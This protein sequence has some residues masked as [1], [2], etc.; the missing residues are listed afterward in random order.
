MGTV[1]AGHQALLVDLYELTMAAGYFENEVNY[2]STF[3]L[4]VRELP[5][6]R[7]YLVAAG[8]EQVVDFLESVQFQSEEIEFLRSHPTFAHVRKEF[9]DYLKH[10]RFSG[11]LWAMP[12]GTLVFPGEPIL[13]VSAPLI[14]AQIMETYLLSMINCQTMIATKATRVVAAA[15]GR[16]VIEFG[17][18]RAHGPEAGVLAARAAY[19]GGC[20]GTSNVYAGF[21]MGIPIYGTAAHSW[22]MT[23]ED[24]EEAFEKYCRVFPDSALLLID[25]YNTVEGARKAARMGQKVKGVRI[26]SGDLLKTSQQVRTILDDAGLSGVQILASGDLNE[27]KVR[28]LVQHGAPIDVFGVGTELSTSHDAP[29]LGGVYKLV[30]QTVE[31][32]F[33]YRIKLSPQKATYPGKKQVFRFTNARDQFDHDVIARD[34]ES[35]QG[36]PLLERVMAEGHRLGP[37]PALHIARERAALNF[38][39]LQE[40]YAAFENPD[41]YPVINSQALEELFQKMKHLN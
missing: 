13:R 32:S 40:R 39:R 14:E 2:P 17:S 8:L 6:K 22:T 3:E 12:E 4:F 11:D 9:F 23:F 35:S 31:N 37:L 7:S 24:E 33:R 21:R 41:T 36:A 28:D 38:S 10:F 30:E 5:E 1:T 29:A 34:Q 19:I 25:T 18:R 16:G 20:V 27:Y 15:G 26:D